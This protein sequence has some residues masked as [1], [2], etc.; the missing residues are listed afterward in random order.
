MAWPALLL[1]SDPAHAYYGGSAYLGGL[2]AFVVIVIHRGF[3]ARP[4][5]GMGHFHN[6]VRIE[7]LAN[8]SGF[9]DG[10]CLC[11]IHQLCREAPMQERLGRCVG[12]R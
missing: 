8:A 10:L 9:A 6:S 3:M 1:A 12:R 4:G 2:L 7:P 11:G 5:I